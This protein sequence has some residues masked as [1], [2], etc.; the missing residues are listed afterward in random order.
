MTIFQNQSTSN[1]SFPVNLTLLGTLTVMAGATIAPSLPAMQQHFS[2]VDNVEYWVRL[3][4]TVPV[5][6]I[7][8]PLSARLSINWDA[9][10]VDTGPNPVW[11]SRQFRGLVERA[12]IDPPGTSL[13]RLQCCGH[14]ITAT[15]LIADYYTGRAGK[16][17]ACRP[18]LCP[19]ESFS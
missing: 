15:A 19:W 5:L 6:A 8:A 9:N 16:F 17:S 3:V 11:V 18:P 12:R 7:S 10:L 13:V 2:E 1:Q 4:L 14:Q